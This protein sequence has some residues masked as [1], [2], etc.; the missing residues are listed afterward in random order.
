MNYMFHLSTSLF[1][2]SFGFV[3]SNTSDRCLW[4]GRGFN[5]PDY[6]VI[7]KNANICTMCSIPFQTEPCTPS[8][9]ELRFLSKS[10]L[11][12][13]SS[14]RP[15]SPLP[16][17]RRPSMTQ[18]GV[19]RSRAREWESGWNVLKAETFLI[20]HSHRPYVT[21]PDHVMGLC[22]SRG[23]PK[24]YLRHSRTVT[25]LCKPRAYITARR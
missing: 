13:P 16:Q 12:S 2:S 7:L 5:L 25:R 10:P 14:L 22:C 9:N 3:L 20:V 23:K 18:F 24:H 6:T 17:F 8:K 15:L 4:W 1:F 11:C 19:A 21:Q